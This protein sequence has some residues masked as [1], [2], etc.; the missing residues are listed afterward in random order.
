MV[1]RTESQCLEKPHCQGLGAGILEYESLR[2]QAFIYRWLSFQN[3][4][5]I[6]KQQ[7]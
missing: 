7:Q 1:A 6:D 5:R 4:L 2:C 3:L